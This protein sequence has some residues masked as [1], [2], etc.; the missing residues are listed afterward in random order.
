VAL[1]EEPV[2]EFQLPTF[3]PE[4]F[5]D[6]IDEIKLLGIP[7]CNVFDL[8][9][10]DISQY[11]PAREMHLH[12]GKNISMLG[13]FITSKLVRTVKGQ[14]MYFGTFIDSHGDWIDSVHFHNVAD[15][16]AIAGKGFYHMKGKVVEEFGVYSIEVQA[17]T[18]IGLKV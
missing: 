17:I 3:T 1:F 9:D 7:L 16:Y 6:V 18:A 10:T 4:P 2:K 14:L 12:V 8:V 11:V 5:E 13:Y 15:K